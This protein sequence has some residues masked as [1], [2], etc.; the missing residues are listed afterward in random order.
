[1]KTK[2]LVLMLILAFG[3]LLTG[4]GT[5]SS[6]STSGQAAT[7]PTIIPSPTVAAL[8]PDQ[9]HAQWVDALRNNDRQAALALLPPE[10][11]ERVDRVL[12]SIQT[13]IHSRV[14]GGLQGVDLDPV[15]DR[16]AGKLGASR[17]RYPNKTE[18]FETSLALIAGT[19]Q[20]VLWE[21]Q[22]C[23]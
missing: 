23:F 5:T 9:V 6:A 2:Y 11:Q 20:V 18:C 8:T 4:C 15:V 16:G 13:T 21:K 1:M 19:W 7:L 3:A 22:P 17:W 10:H 14:L 12:G